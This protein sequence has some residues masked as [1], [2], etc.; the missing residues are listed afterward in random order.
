MSVKAK[1][2]RLVNINSGEFNIEENFWILNPQLKYTP[3]FQD[4]YKRDRSKKKVKS[5]KD[6]WCIWLLSD[7]CYE[8]KVYR[9]PEDVKQVM[10]DYYNPDF[11]LQDELHQE[12]MKAYPDM[13]L[14][15]VARS[16]REEEESLV[17]RT[18]IIVSVQKAI[19]EL[20][21]ANPLSVADKD[22]QAL[23]AKI[24]KM[25][26]DGTSI[27]KE[28]NETKRMFEEEQ[29]MTSRVY[30]GRDETIREKGQ[31]LRNLPKEEYE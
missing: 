17:D 23:M 29:G 16:F 15:N 24:E 31:L 7:P 5:S 6:M 21:D 2:Y 20:V 3:P 4:A 19:A 11:E 13:C 30:G 10:I 25:R 14:T 1:K 8:N 26:K 28:Y 9:M 22:T 12:I 18:G 27:R